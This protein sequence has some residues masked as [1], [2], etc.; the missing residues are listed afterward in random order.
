MNYNGINNISKKYWFLIQLWNCMLNFLTNL[1]SFF[2]FHVI[3]ER[4]QVYNTDCQNL[5]HELL[6]QII[7]RNSKIIGLSWPPLSNHLAVFFLYL[8]I[9][10]N[11]KLTN[12]DTKQVLSSYKSLKGIN[13][14]DRTGLLI[15]GN[16]Y[17]CIHGCF[18]SPQSQ[19]SSQLPSSLS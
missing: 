7:K 6:L 11:F 10:V 2:L 9:S 14:F 13:F 3:K 18:L 15:Q 16:L 4:I 12:L 5:K 1:L 17:Q 19:W 8:F